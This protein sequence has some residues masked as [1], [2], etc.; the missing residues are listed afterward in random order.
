MLCWPI[1]PVPWNSPSRGTRR[2]LEFAWST[3]TACASPPARGAWWSLMASVVTD[4]S[5]CYGRATHGLA[6]LVVTGTSGHVTLDALRWLEGAGVGL[7]VL[8]PASGDVTLASTAVGNDDARLRRSQGL[9]MGTETGLKVAR[10]L[11]ALKLAGQA[12]V[13]ADD[14]SAHGCRRDDPSPGRAGG[15]IGQSGRAST[16]GGH[17]GKSLLVSVGRGRDEIRHQG[18]P[19]STGQLATLRGPTLHGHPRITSQFF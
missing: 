8:D 9:A 17:G 13:A 5:A 19:P 10:Y 11:I 3:G 18:R 12:T 6:R 16:T 1:R 4:E 15:R 14:L 7:V 2:T